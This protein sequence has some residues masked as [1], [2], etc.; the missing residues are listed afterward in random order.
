MAGRSTT[1]TD[2]ANLA[3]SL[4]GEDAVADIASPETEAGEKLSRWLYQAIDEVESEYLWRELQTHA[5]DVTADATDHYDGRKRYALPTD[6]LRPLGFKITDDSSALNPLVRQIGGYDDL[7]Y[8]VCGDFLVTNMD[9][10]IDIIYVK[11]SD[12]PTEWTPE[13]ERC[14]AYNAAI[15]AGQNITSDFGIVKNLIVY[16]QTRIEPKARRLQSKY[17]GNKKFL[18]RNYTYINLAY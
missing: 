5:A 4:L 11:R 2:I 8:E 15:K 1:I 17:K 10:T 13:L 7:Q 12:T 14:V 9:S 3:L 18:P 6:C 16:Y